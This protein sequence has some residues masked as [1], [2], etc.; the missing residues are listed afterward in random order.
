MSILNSEGML[1]LNYYSNHNSNHLVPNEVTQSKNDLLRIVLLLLTWTFQNLSK[2]FQSFIQICNS[3]LNTYKFQLYKNDNLHNIL[4]NKLLHFHN[5]LILLIPCLKLQLRQQSW[6]KILLCQHE[7]YHDI[8]FIYI[9][10][11]L[12]NEQ[13]LH[14]IFNT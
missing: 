1:F 14:H 3:N 9:L 13:L 5:T 8:A 6:H 12:I 2:L 11:I 10:K 4:L 7:N